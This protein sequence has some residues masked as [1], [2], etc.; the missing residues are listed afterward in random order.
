MLSYYCNKKQIARAHR[1]YRKRR[2]KSRKMT[3]YGL[4][5]ECPENL[6]KKMKKSV[7]KVIPRWYYSQAVRRESD[8]ESRWKPHNNSL[9]RLFGSLGS[10]K[11]F[12]K[13][14]K[15]FLTKWTSRD[16]INRLS[17]EM[18][19]ASR[20]LKIEQNWNLWNLIVGLETHVNQFQITS[21]SNRTQ[22]IVSEWFTRL[23]TYK[24]I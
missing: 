7:D 10:R 12:K 23:N 13:I 18:R 21:N 11:N 6:S 16:I 14:S 2:L 8:T 1:Q 24:V 22:A 19:T 9:W 15:K 5:K 4:T 17:R 3:L 20:T